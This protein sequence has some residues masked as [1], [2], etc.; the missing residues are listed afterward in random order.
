MNFTPCFTKKQM[1]I[2]ILVVY[3]LFK[4]YK[5]NSLEA[6]AKSTNTN[7]QRLQ[8]FIS[9]SKW[10]IQAIK[11]KRL[12]I[13]QQQRTTAS[14]KDGIVAF[15]DTACPKPFAK[16]TQ[17]A[18]WQYC[19]PLKREE[20]CN[21][22][23]ASAFVSQTKHFP[24]DIVP[25]IPADEFKGGKDNPEFKDKIQIAIELFNNAIET[26]DIPG[27][28]FD[29]WYAST[30]FIEHIHSK[31]RVFFSEIKSNRNIFMYH[32][33][34]KTHCMVK[35]DEL[36]TLIKRHYWHKVKYVK[37]KTT[38]GSEVSYKTYSFETK[39]KDCTVPIKF[40]VVFGKWSKE[41][42]KR[43]H[44]LITNQLK[45]PAKTVIK[46]YLLR[47]GIEY[48]FKELKDTFYFDH[49]QVR[50]IDKIER[51]WNLCLI[52]W[53]LTYWI[54]QNAYLNKILETKPVTFNEFKQAINSLLEFSATSELSKNETLANEYF[55]IKSARA[56]K[57]M[58]A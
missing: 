31:D 13:I 10:D 25:Y 23:V 48:C 16:K 7:Y 8:Y 27:V 33:V 32:P 22:A 47:W 40:V 14:T 36:V 9:D 6:M 52:A 21:V 2:F 35:P 5:R 43:F 49:Y 15:D 18:Q 56:I 46:N 51:Y 17:G 54:K 1:A 37:H 50:H 44:I 30:K 26:L 39:L 41:D 11:Q 53:T 58:A 55:K 28:T 45:A 57:K 24:I 38:D 20:T 19:A 12:E 34:K 42:D 4:D 3:A 29:S